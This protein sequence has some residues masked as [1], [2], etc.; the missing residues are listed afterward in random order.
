MNLHQIQILYKHHL[1]LYQKRRWTAESSLFSLEL[2]NFYA[3]KLIEEGYLTQEEHEMNKLPIVD[4]KSLF[5]HNT[6]IVIGDDS[7]NGVD[8]E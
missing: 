4:I 6:D 7:N 2:A 8:G 3:H 5:K 1:E